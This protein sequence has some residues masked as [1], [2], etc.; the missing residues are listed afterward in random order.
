MSP[1][2]RRH[3]VL[4]GLPGAGKTEV[5]RRL[6][7][8]LHTRFTDLDLDIAAR[9]G[10]PVARIFAEQGERTF[11]QLEREAMGAALAEPPQVIAAGGG[12]ATEPGNLAAV[13]GRALLVYLRVSPA[14]AARRLGPVHGRPLLESDVLAGLQRLQAERASVYERATVTVDTDDLDPE[15]VATL[16]AG[17]AKALRW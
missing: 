17:H 1:P 8:A 4:I 16:V 7:A 5:G 6:A 15:E 9:A 11:R 3:V 14:A 13:E 12:W 2:G 10:M